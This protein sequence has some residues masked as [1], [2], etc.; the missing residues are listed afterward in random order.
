[1]RFAPKTKQEGQAA[2]LFARENGVPIYH[3]TWDRFFGE[4]SDDLWKGYP[5]IAFD[6]NELSGDL[7]TE[8]AVGL[9]EFLEMLVEGSSRIVKLNENYDAEVFSDRVKVGCQD[10]PFS[11]IEK[12]MEAINKQKAK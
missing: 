12:L 3:H 10:I 7:N 5:S 6:N 11:A 8:D 1:M 4:D 2:L 9:S